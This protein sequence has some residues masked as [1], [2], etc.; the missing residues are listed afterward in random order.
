MSGQY[1]P[2]S[3]LNFIQ[4]CSHDQNIRK[5]IPL[6]STTYNPGDVVTFDLPPHCT[7]DLST[8]KV[9][10]YASTSGQP[11]ATGKTPAVCLP[12]EAETL[13]S[14][15]QCTSNGQ[16][17]SQGP[18]HHAHLYSLLAKHMLGD[19]LPDRRILGN[20]SPIPTSDAGY[21]QTQSA[22]ANVV[23]GM[24]SSQPIVWS[25]FLD[26]LSSTEQIYD[27]ELLP[28]RVEMTLASPNVL[29]FDN[30]NTLSGSQSFT[31]SGLYATICVWQ[32]PTEYYVSQQRY[33]NAGN[34]ISRLFNKWTSFNGS[35][36]PAGQGPT[37]V[38]RFQASFNSLDLVLGTFINGA[39]TG[40]SGVFADGVAPDAFN[41][42]SWSLAKHST[43]NVDTFSNFAAD[44][45]SWGFTVNS[46]LYP[47]IGAVDNNFTYSFMSDVLG[48]SQDAHSIA[49][50]RMLLSNDAFVRTAWMCGV[51]F[52][53]HTD[54]A[55]RVQSGLNSAHSSTEV[56]FTTTGATANKGSITTSDNGNV[57]IPLIFCKSSSVVKIGSACQFE[58]DV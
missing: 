7:C 6:N 4:R 16:M 40:S 41:G 30:T 24:V 42:Q 49:N 8:L 33:L 18:Q 50:P 15:I 46:Q 54:P 23:G 1:M 55:D 14:R 31:L 48:T 17:V 56:T 58:L 52:A 19:K 25:H 26:F 2:K 45:A 11:A 35:L 22:N 38:T 39:P 36:I 5:I 10:S 51:S 29:G 28:L 27:T 47:Q 37:Q 3:L 57:R 12:R 44:V 43:G 34:V 20:A 9:Y 32:L 21:N 13:I 53:L